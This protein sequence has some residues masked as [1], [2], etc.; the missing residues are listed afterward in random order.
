MRVVHSEQDLLDALRSPQV[1]VSADLVDGKGRRSVRRLLAGSGG[2]G[3]PQATP[4]FS[5]QHT[6][7]SVSLLGWLRSG[8]S[9]AFARAARRINVGWRVNA[10]PLRARQSA[11]TGAPKTGPFSARRDSSSSVLADGSAGGPL[12]P[13]SYRDVLNRLTPQPQRTEP[14]ND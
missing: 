5:G 12:T 10:F 2:T 7:K 14:A 3:A 4:S 13:A 8:V 6:R 9:V 11:G 1:F